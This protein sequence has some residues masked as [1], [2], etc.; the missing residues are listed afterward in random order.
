MGGYRR[1]MSNL[2]C[3]FTGI[4]IP[5]TVLGWIVR[6][7]FR[8]VAAAA[9]YRSLAW[10]LGLEADTRGRSV[11]GE[12]EGRRVFIGATHPTRPTS[13]VELTVELMV[14]LGVGLAIRSRALSDRWRRPA[15]GALGFGDR[16]V[17]DRL[18][19]TARERASAAPLLDDPVRD[20][21]T[22]LLGRGADLWVDDRT[23]RATLRAAPS[24]ERQLRE[25]LTVIGD[26]AEALERPREGV[27]LPEPLVPHEEGWLQV[28]DHHGLSRRAGA[29]ALVG[30]PGDRL[31]RVGCVREHERFSANL[32]LSFRP[33]HPTGLHIRPHLSDEPPGAT[34]QDIAV[35]DTAF[36][37]TF[38]VRGYDP[39][40]V[41]ALLHERARATLLHL[42]ALGTVQVTDRGLDLDGLATSADAVDQAIERA[43]A[44]ADALGW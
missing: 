18:E 41:R 40:T 2:L 38:I 44:L 30:E 12:V 29:L 36:D 42:A 35:D 32:R 37:R 21:L 33:H 22:A 14:P 8:P 34:G 25:L 9:A 11:R 6:R 23:V 10:K 20:A 15:E 19:I 1:P 7:G 26:L 24:G 43:L 16:A 3:L 13:P 4:L 28:A 17:D 31:L 5:L 39:A 27:P